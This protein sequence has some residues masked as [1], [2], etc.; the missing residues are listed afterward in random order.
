MGQSNS[1]RS[2][3]PSVSI[4]KESRLPG[5]PPGVNVPGRPGPRWY[6]RGLTRTR[7]R[8]LAVLTAALTTA[9][10]A[11]PV[12]LFLAARARAFSALDLV[13][14]GD[15]PLEPD[16]EIGFVPARNAR[17][18]RR[19]P[20]AGL[21]YH[22]FTDDRRARVGAPG[23][24]TPARVDVATIGCSFSWGHGVEGAETYS[25]RLGERLRVPVANLAFSA[26]GTLQSLQTL[27][28][29]R[30]LAPRVVVYGV[31]QDHLKR[32]VSPCAPTFGPACLPQSSV[33]FQGGAP[34]V[35]PPRM[36][37]YDFNRRFWDAFFRRRVGAGP[38]GL[39]LAAEAELRRFGRP[40]EDDTPEERQRALAWL[41]DQLAAETRRLGAALLVVHIPYLEPG[42]TN[43]APAALSDAV[44]ALGTADVAL[45]DLA[46][47]VRRHHATPGAE[48]LRF[49]RDR[50]PNAAAHALVAGEIEPYVARRL[51]RVDSPPGGQP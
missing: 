27:R 22:V 25:A 46:G 43:D 1:C 34:L 36:A 41:V 48:P 32:N 18:V 15:F 17:T 3:R 19:H 35:R 9:A 26:Y 28:R 33:A 16:E 5:R 49:P 21:A 6:H 10:C 7:R 47:A 8:T 23:E 14:E 20:R 24:Q 4:E 38:E 2:G 37:D 42:T 45:L 40:R 12:L 11:V 51:A 50:H 30:G 31:I 39:R 44:R 29:A 13:L